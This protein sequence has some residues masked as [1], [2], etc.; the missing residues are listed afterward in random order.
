MKLAVSVLGKPVA[1]LESVGDFK[2]VLTYEEGVD[3]NNL[4]SLTMPVRTESW[5]WDD[6]LHP[7]F[8]MNLPE[9]YLLHVL[10]EQFGRHIGASPITLLSIVGRNMIGRLQVAVS[11]SDLNEPVTP[12]DVAELLKG[13]NSE[14]AFSA[15]VAEEKNRVSNWM[16]NCPAAAFQL[17]GGLFHF[18]V[19]LRK[20]R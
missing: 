7:I 20:A 10:E 18:F 19:T 3:P 13:D 16:A 2:S 1:T 14:A 9:G 8:R 12:L 15:L 11:G 17:I 6:P 5:I 4:V